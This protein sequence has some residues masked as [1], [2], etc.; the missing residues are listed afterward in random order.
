MRRNAVFYLSPLSL[1]LTVIYLKGDVITRFISVLFC[2]LV[3]VL[4]SCGNSDNVA[5]TLKIITHDSFDV[6]QQLIDD[7][8]K[9]N[10]IHVEVI[11]AGDANQILTRSILNAGNPE[12]DL[13]FGIDNIAYKRI[14]NF[15][16]LLIPYVSPN[17][18]QIPKEI[19]NA[20][21]DIPYFTPI[22]YGYVS[23]NYD[24]KFNQQDPPKKL[25]EL[26]LPIWNNQFIVL[27]PAISS[28]GL[29]FLIST[30]AYFGPDSWLDFWKGLKQNN[31]LVT[32]SWTSGYYTHFSQNGGERPLV[33][34]Y[35][36]SPAAEAFFGGLD[37]PPTQN[38]IFDNLFRQ[39][40]SVSILKGSENIVNAKKFIDFML[41]D[42]FQQQIPET[43]FVYPVK[44]DL[45][46]PEWW[47]MNPEITEIQ[48]FRF[49]N[50][51]LQVWITEW[52]KAMR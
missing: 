25:E 51:E 23:I 34:S 24:Q 33:V 12:G 14:N 29:Q 48:N 46:L 43:M 38:I 42:P 7:F 52:S 1:C 26:L 44:Q 6:K 9:I 47:S 40:E 11:K 8:S 49:S 21:D 19:L 4:L 50:K 18:K 2:S 37:R 13:I 30:I 31:V 41:T 32:D 10:D 45:K 27:D 35:T 28:P 3:I 5:G 22:D 20:F 39:V 15:S 36:S 17:R 16:E